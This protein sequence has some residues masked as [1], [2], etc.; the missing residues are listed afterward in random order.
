MAPETL[1]MQAVAKELGVDRSALNYHVADRRALLELVAADILASAV[2]ST[3]LAP[4]GDWQDT[5]R[6]FAWQVRDAMVRAGGFSTHFRFPAGDDARQHLG[7]PE[8]VLGELIDAGLDHARAVRV[9]SMLT[10][11]AA[12]SARDV[13][14]AG[15]QGAHPQLPEMVHVLGEQGAEELPLMRA[16]LTTWDPASPEQFEF[17]LD[18]FIRGVQQLL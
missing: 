18:V 6:A 7:P 3:A 13:T 10:Q 12:A 11:L 17:N 14:A 1:T 8:Q 9:L 2:G 5:V 16:L 15:D 4:T